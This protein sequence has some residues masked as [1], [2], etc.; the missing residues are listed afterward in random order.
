MSFSYNALHLQLFVSNEQTFFYKGCHVYFPDEPFNNWFV[1]W[2]S[3]SNYGA[4]G[5][6]GDHER[7][8]LSAFQSFRVNHN[9][10]ERSLQYGPI[11]LYTVGEIVYRNVR[12]E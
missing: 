9:S 11:V 3:P 5:K 10:M 7:S 2:R 6:F 8:V 12:L 4:C 1:F